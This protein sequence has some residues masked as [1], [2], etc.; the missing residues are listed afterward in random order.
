MSA[1]EVPWTP[2]ISF[3]NILFGMD[4]SP[5]SLRALPFAAGIA[6]HFGGKIFL[7]HVIRTEEL[8]PNVMAA[9]AEIDKLEAGAEEGSLSTLRGGLGQVMHEVVLEHGELGPR[10]AEAAEQHNIDL[11]V[12]GTHGWRGV[13]KLVR[14]STAEELALLAT[15]PVLTVGPR[16]TSGCDFQ[17]VLY[18]TDF[19]PASAFAFPYAASIAHSYDALLM[20][21]H[22]NEWASKEAPVDAERNADEFF[23][24]QLLGY[25]YADSSVNCESVVRFGARDERIVELAVHRSADLIVMGLNCSKALRPRLSAHLPGSTEYQ[26]IAEAP[27]PVLTVPFTG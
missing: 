1:A 9:L 2:R 19:S 26:V 15:R 5:S 14:G 25:G 3:R 21:L 27:C 4:L 7:A 6:R 18:E 20:L 11:I 16:V 8:D 12:V 17:R 24:K 23:K 10:L 22:V 13:R